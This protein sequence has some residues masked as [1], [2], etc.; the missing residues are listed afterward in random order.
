MRTEAGFV[1]CTILCVC[2]PLAVPAATTNS[3]QSPLPP[4]EWQLQNQQ[5]LKR[6]RR[7]TPAKTPTWVNA[8]AD[9]IA[10]TLVEKHLFKDGEL[11]GLAKASPDQA[12]P[13]DEV[14]SARFI[15]LVNQ[16]KLF[17]KVGQPDEATRAKTL[18]YWQSWQ[19]LKTGRFNDPRDP[20]RVVNEKYVVGVIRGLGGEPLHPWTDTSDSGK[21]ETQLFLK[22]TKDDPDWA[23]GGWGVGSHT[24]FQALEI[25]SAI[26]QGQTNLISDLEQGLEQMLSHQHSDGLWGPPS[27]G[28]MRRIGGTLKVV[29]RLY[30]HMGMSVPH[31]RELADSLIQH[32]RDG[33]WFKD[34]KSSCVPRNV[35]E[36]AAYCIEVSDYR[37]DELLEVLDKLVEDYQSW[38]LPDGR[39]LF[40][41]GDTNSVGLE[42]VTM[43]GLGLIGAYLN[44]DDCRLP[45]PLADSR[46]G[47]GYRYRP[48]L[49]ADGKV[50]VVDSKI[51]GMTSE[52]PETESKLAAIRSERARIESLLPQFVESL[53][54]PGK[55]YG[56]FK[57]HKFQEQPWLLYASQQML[58]LTVRHGL[59]D[60]LD[61]TKKREWLALLLSSQDPRTGLFRCPV[62]TNRPTEYYRSITLKMARVLRSIGVK[63]RYPLPKAETICPDLASLP[64]ALAALPWDSKAYSSGSQ[65]G[66]WAV[67]R[68]NELADRNAPLRDDPYVM[69]IIRFL[70]SHQNAQTGFWGT[71]PS[72]EDGMNGLLKTLSAFRMLK[73]PLPQPEKIVDSL[74]SVQEPDG[75]FGDN[76]S[77]WNAMELLTALHD[78]TNYRLADVQR[79]GLKLADTVAERRQ[80]DGLYSASRDGCVSVHADVRLCSGPMPV[81]DIQGTSQTLSILKMI[82]SLFED[83]LN[84]TR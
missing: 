70:E 12:L 39:T 78:Q 18:R 5:L 8:I 54:L 61:E 48:M 23:A 26:N 42:F 13:F 10:D 29:G 50:K 22:R 58:S 74:L 20:K 49:Q 7:P 66:H 1:L 3:A 33:G 15:G 77:P 43:Y 65:A 38:V 45:N 17:D 75:N 67:T 14:G 60:K 35:A 79:A 9:G 21:V 80:P 62:E 59:W 19:D 72:L 6:V 47:Q 27:A 16:Y 83:G 82:E 56:R 63:P 41:R 69:T 11:W 52:N 30:F 57:F 71:S 51:E 68:L 32:S 4:A 55:P 25:L 46:R 31:T 34:G 81:G 64:S 28:L 24:G 40:R 36:V 76:C 84:R 37:R 44:W 53:A 73:R 2:C